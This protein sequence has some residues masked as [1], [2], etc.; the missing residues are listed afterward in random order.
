[1]GATRIPDIKAALNSFFEA[2][3]ILGTNN[4]PLSPVL[5]NV[6]MK[7]ANKIMAEE[8]IKIWLEKYAP[9]LFWKQE[10]NHDLEHG[11]KKINV[12]KYMGLYPHEFLF[13]ISNATSRQE[14][15]CVCA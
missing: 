1:M 6:A 9:V 14:Y 15:V 8:K 11:K 13:L 3:R 12:E 2:E 7:Y 10:Y 4:I 5:L